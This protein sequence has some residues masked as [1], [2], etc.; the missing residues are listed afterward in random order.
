MTDP[1]VKLFGSAVRVKLLRLFL[2]NPRQSFT[3]AEAAAR[4]RAS[5]DDAHHE[6]ALFQHVGVVARS[7]RGKGPRYVLN[8]NFEYVREMQNLLLNTS[9]QGGAIA[10]RVRGAGLFRLIIL[11]GIFTGEWDSGLDVLF[12]GE[13]TND[14]K[15]RERMR[16]LEAELGRELRYT[17]LSTQDFMYRLNMSDKLIRDVLDYPHQIVVDKL[18]IGLK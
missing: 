17:L 3:V 6:I 15:L 13:R 1:L 5:A 2:F 12:V 9:A 18:Q 8:G 7:G 14:R 11:S 4:A 10:K 16:A